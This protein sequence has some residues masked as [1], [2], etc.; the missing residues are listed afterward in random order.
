MGLTK[1]RWTIERTL[2]R[3]VP[4]SL[5]VPWKVVLQ[6]YLAK[7]KSNAKLPSVVI[8]GNLSEEATHS[9]YLGTDC[10]TWT[11]VC[12]RDASALPLE[13]SRERLVLSPPERQS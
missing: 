2:N 8:H 11:N 3:P 1:L 6:L 10:I 7:V 4:A 12:P 13:V 5:V 9:Q